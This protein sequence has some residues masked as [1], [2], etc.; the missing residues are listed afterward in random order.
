VFQDS[1][2]PFNAF[3]GLDTV[4]YHP[5]LSST[6]TMSIASNSINSQPGEK[7]ENTRRE[8]GW[9]THEGGEGESS[10]RQKSW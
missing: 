10:H 2:L 1:I 8:R 4:E 5:V 7:R 9:R 6:I 3:P